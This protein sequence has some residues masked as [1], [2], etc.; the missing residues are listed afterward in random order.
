[1]FPMMWK[2]RGISF[3]ELITTL[4]ELAGERYKKLNRIQTTF[5]SNLKF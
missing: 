2:E 1:M 3:T 4:V 5:D